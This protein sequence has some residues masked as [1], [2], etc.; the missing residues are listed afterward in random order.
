MIAFEA[1]ALFLVTLAIGA[2]LIWLARGWRRRTALGVGTVVAAL[3]LSG[4]AAHRWMPAAFPKAQENQ[5]LV[6]R[7]HGYVGSGTCR[8][9]H[10]RNYDTWHHSYHRTMTQVVRPDTFLGALGTFEVAGRSYRLEQRGES[11]IGSFS[12]SGADRREVELVMSTGSHHMQVYWYP[13]GNGSRSVII[14]TIDAEP[15]GAW[16]AGD[17]IVAANGQTNPSVPKQPVEKDVVTRYKLE[18]RGLEFMQRELVPAAD[19]LAALCNTERDARR[20]SLQRY[21][22]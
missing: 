9:C 15:G 22:L 20:S 11:I 21:E 3:V 5:P 16:A 7:A 4:F 14:N 12:E 10:P 18:E 6:E 2:W 13:T 8:S 19:R 17:Q 1:A